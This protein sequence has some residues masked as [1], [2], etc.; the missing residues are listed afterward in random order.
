MRTICDFVAVMTDRYA[1][2]FYARL[3]GA[4]QVTMH[5]PF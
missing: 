2:E 3:R 5:K 1:M 4:G